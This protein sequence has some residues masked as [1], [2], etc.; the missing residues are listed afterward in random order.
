MTVV[1]SK[2]FITN[3]N[4]YFD[5]AEN[6]QVYIQRGANMFIVQNYVPSEETEIY[7]QPNDELQSCITMN[8]LRERTR[9]KIHQLFERK[10]K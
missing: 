4:K 8:E 1:S 7:F 3:E 2:E 10:K 9:E 5:L 6:G